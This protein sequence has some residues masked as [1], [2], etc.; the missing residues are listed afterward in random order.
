MILFLAPVVGWS[1]AI[2]S[3]SEGGPWDQTSTWV[4]G[5]VPVFNNSS[6][7][8]IVGPVNVSSTVY[9]S[10]TPLVI[11]QTTINTGGILTVDA[12]A[13][14]NVENAAIDLVIAGTGQLQVDGTL[15]QLPAATF[16]GT[17][18]SN[19]FFNAGS[20]YEHRNTT[21]GILLTAS[22]NGAST[23]LVTGLNSGSDA[24]GSWLQNIGNFTFNCPN[25]VA[26]IANLN[27]NLRNIAGTFNVVRTGTTGRLMFTNGAGV[28]PISIGGDLIIGDGT[29]AAAFWVTSTGTV[30]VNVAGTVTV[31]TTSATPSQNATTGTGIIQINNDGN[32]LLQSGIWNFLSGAGTGTITLN[33]GNFIASLGTQVRRT[34]A[35]NATVSF[36]GAGDQQGIDLAP[37]L[38]TSGAVNLNLGKSSGNLNLQNDLTIG[39][40]TQTGGALVLGGNALT[41]N[42]VINQ[43]TGNINANSS[44]N[45]TIGG[46]GSISPGLVFSPSPAI[47]GVLTMNRSGATLNTTSVFEVNT[48]NLTAGTLTNGNLTIEDQGTINVVAGVLTNVPSAAGVYDVN[49]SNA[50][51]LNT[52]NELPDSPSTA[53]RNLSKPAG[54]GVLSLTKNIEINGSLTLSAGTFAAGA[55]SILLDGNFTSNGAFTTAVGG[56]FT[57]AGATSS[58]TGST[59]PVFRDLTIGGSFTPNLNYGVNGNYIVNPGALVQLGTGGVTFGGTTTITNNG[60]IFFNA[61]TIAATF[62]MTAPS[63]ILGIAGNFTNTGTFNNG[64]GTILFNGTTV[65]S[66]SAV[67][68]DVTVTVTGTVSAANISQTIAGNLIN[69]GTFN[70]SNTIAAP[71]TGNLT[72]SGSGTLSGSGNTTVA[73][74]NVTGASFTYTATGNLTLNDDI[75]G[76]GTFNSSS[77]TAGTVIFAG[78]GSSIAGAG[79]RTFRNLSVTGTLTPAFAYTLAGSGGLSV[80]GTLVSGSTVIFGGTSQTITGSGTIAFNFVTINVGSTLIVTPNITI[81]NNLIGNG[82]ITANGTVTFVGLTMSGTGAKN[83]TNVTVGTGT[84]TPNANYSISG[85]LVVNGTLAAGNATTTFNGNTTISGAGSATFNFLTVANTLTS[86][87]GTISIVRDFTNNG[88]FNHAGGTVSFSTAGTV[89]RQILGTSST[90][91][92]N[93]IINNVGVATDVTNGLAGGLSVDI[94]GT[95]SFG[96]ENAVLDADGSGTSVLRIVSTNDSPAADGR[97]GAVTFAGSNITGNFTVQRFVSNEATGRFYRYIASPVVGASVAQL[98]AV[99]PVT[100]TFSDPSDGSSS[101]P[102]T[103]CIS[104]NP[105]L[106]SFN[107]ATASTFVAF[108][109]SGLASASSFTNGR[110]YSAFFRHT[111]LGATGSIA[112]SFR[113][114]NPSTAAISLPVSPNA[115]GY[116]LVGNPYPSP[117]VWGATGWTR[118]NI[119]DV[120]VVRNNATGIHESHGTADNF[121]IASGQSFWVQ[122]TALGAALQIAQTA[123]YSGVASYE[124]YRS[125]DPIADQ[126]ELHLTKGTT[127]VSDNARLVVVAGS[128]L[129][130][131]PF[132][133]FKFN[134]TIDNGDGTNTEVQDVSIVSSDLKALHVNAI[135]SISCGQVFNLR[136]TNFVNSTETVVEYKLNVIPS[137][138]M[139][140][141]SWVLRDN[142][143]GLDVDVSSQ[144]TYIFSVDNLIP[145][146]KSSSRFTLK[147]ASAS[148]IDLSRSVSATASVCST[149]DL[150]ISVASQNGLAYSTE[151]NGVYEPA[152]LAVG[153]GSTISLLVDKNKLINGSNTI[154]LKASS[155]CDQQFLMGSVVVMKE[156]AFEIS[157]T[158]GGVLCNTGSLSLAATSLQNNANFKWYLNEVSTTP[159]ATG[160]R[161]IT[162]FLSDSTTY[163]VAAVSPNGCEGTRVPVNVAFEDIASSLS[164][165]GST[166]VCKG[167]SINLSV[168]SAMTGGSFKWYD[169]PNAT[170]VIATSSELNVVSIQ[171]SKSFYVSFLSSAG[172]ESDRVEVKAEVLSYSPLLET[173]NVSSSRCAGNVQQ[174]IA[175]GGG[176]QASYKWFDVPNATQPLAQGFQFET[177]PIF[178]DKTYF[179]ESTNVEGCRSERVPVV[180]SVNA[181]PSAPVFAFS[182]G[183]ICNSGETSVR[184]NNPSAGTLY[185]W[186]SSK[187]S[188]Q[189]IYEG[190]SMITQALSSRTSYFVSCVNSSGCESTD[191]KEV[192]VDVTQFAQPTIDSSNP[193]RLASNYSDDNQWYFDN[194]ELKGETSQFL[195]PNESGVYDLKVNYNGCFNWAGSVFVTTVVTAIE[196]KRREINV[197]PNPSSDVLRIVIHDR[198]PVN[199]SLLDLKGSFVTGIFLSDFTSGW[200]GHLDV[201]NLAKGIYFLQLS[202][203]NK[204]IVHKVIIN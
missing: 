23:I 118:T 162:P 163:F 169:S 33:G 103:G 79:A 184:I 41:I 64:G 187:L 62:S 89:Q 110:G 134:N 32:F 67:Y 203:G 172:C 115:S 57:F 161:F 15:V 152:V 122:S 102:C 74:V 188:S 98:K 2:V 170:N 60:S 128:S 28:V 16:T 164:V 38:I 157:T 204:K 82:D 8:S 93:L 73:D 160:S 40:Y 29:Q 22:W 1:Q 180:A 39:A 182:Q 186:Y 108:P 27:G 173:Q 92:N 124:F 136:I 197:Y 114:T 68:N 156:D 88:T 106:F 53:L 168:S 181:I 179:L 175:T 42:G 5:V 20:T 142:F 139:K 7:I 116:S 137:G 148:A 129:S 17:S 151:I 19:T 133:G 109:A 24:G 71:T 70:L 10:V 37:S 86:R 18:A 43:T 111:G 76:V 80:S 112:L 34:G 192:F 171:A 104:A 174:F 132:D 198:S 147:A 189:P 159:V 65:L 54:G 195:I 49:Y 119:G 123:K 84:L 130:S 85:N 61:V 141:I 21:F 26:G 105:S 155:G 91:F 46:A 90:V 199:A 59:A 44:T 13:Q 9:N 190:V 95:L 158:T 30:T 126:V 96:E 183:Q 191:R 78:T 99:I 45:M 178:S 12:D 153:D 101:P 63:T 11:D 113:G 83:F 127:G 196:D 143:T 94:V 14:V 185:R 117:I 149:S 140:G 194:Q 145:A 120:I 202:S 154:R 166:A 3:T 4:G 69:N 146:S 72:W 131:D 25:M 135:P 150:S 165:T 100:G 177:S 51:A 52:S 138:S 121:V 50:A 167:E 87:P 56:A 58:L 201:K 35:G 47:F 144:P 200:E 36:I 55:N 193:S 176:E 77:P 125:S 81:N 31:S 75:T 97:V 48:L 6:S 107:E 66:A